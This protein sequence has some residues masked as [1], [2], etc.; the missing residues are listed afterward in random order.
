MN[1]FCLLVLFLPVAVLAYTY[2]V[3]PITV[4]LFDL[5]GLTLPLLP[6]GSYTGDYGEPALPTVPLHVAVP[7]GLRAGGVNVTHLETVE[8]P[9]VHTVA[10]MPEARCF[11][12]EGPYE[13]WFDPVIYSSAGVFPAEP[14]VAAG[15]G[16]ITGC[17]VAAVLFSPFV[18]E[19][20]TGRLGLVTRVEFELEYETVPY[21][22][23]APR[24]L[25]PAVARM[26]ED[27]VRALVLNPQD[28]L[29]PAPVVEPRPVGGNGPTLNGPDVG[30]TAE[31]VMICDSSHVED[32]RP[33]A[34]WKL[35]KGV[36]TAVVTTGW[37]YDNYTGRDEPEQIRNFIIDAFENWSTAYVLLAGDVYWVPERRAF[38]F[39]AGSDDDSAIPCDL[40][41]SDLDGDWNADGDDVWGEWPDD[42]PDMYPDV[43][44]GRLP[45]FVSGSAGRCRDKI[46][47]YETD[48]PEDF[49]ADALLLGADWDESTPGDVFCEHI[50]D[51][52][53]DPYDPITRLYTSLGNLDRAHVLPELEAG[54]CAVVAHCGHGNYNLLSLTSEYLWGSDLTALGNGFE[55]GWYAS[56]G[57]MAGG[58]DRMQSFGENWI[59]SPAGGGLASIMHSRY[60]WY[61]PGNPGNGPGERF[62]R[63]FTRGVFVRGDYNLGAALSWMREWNVPNAKGNPYFLWTLYAVNLLG[64]VETESWT[65]DPADLSVEHPDEY[66]GG[67]LTVTVT[68]GGSPVE[69]A[70]VCLFKEDDEY[71]V[72]FTDPAGEVFWDSL[73]IDTEGSIT[74]TVT[75]HDRRH[76][77]GEMPVP[78]PGAEDAVLRAAANDEGV[79]VSWELDLASGLGLRVLREE[80][81]LDGTVGAPAALHSD[82]L[83]LTAR[84]YL[85]RDVEKGRGYRYLLEVLGADGSLERF[86][87]TQAVIVPEDGFFTLDLAAYPNPAGD[88]VS[89]AYTLP[90][91][92][93]VGLAVYDLSGRLVAALVDSAQSA[94][95]HA[96]MWDCASV[97]PGVYLCRLSTRMGCVTRRLVVVR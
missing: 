52:L 4:E 40:Y 15:G 5:D 48:V 64:P 92:G 67:P 66:T 76:Y 70:R 25:T 75:A 13:A 16:C 97:P 74:V 57:C 71:R 41:F 96:V 68:S 84:R 55:G 33:L 51:L 50:A 80:V 21:E 89:I 20:S 79:L 82:L 77:R 49:A 7:A 63:D 18:Y 90:S 19:P 38:A 62:I 9:G 8:L 65:D 78:N 44:V 59:L 39:Q 36:T 10:P 47:T 24:I 31:W 35:L 83:P 95:D 12:D 26:L 73:D 81:G 43:H 94:G 30:D 56:P 91:C 37:I 6:E 23:R 3:D 28:V 58:F 69:G 46:L 61:Y 72:G 22:V 17:G 1:R 88:G 29:L 85:D 27:R 11:G 34:E 42:E 32:L 14:L 45:V 53:P 87:P 60:S 54:N 2:E 86:G 93:L